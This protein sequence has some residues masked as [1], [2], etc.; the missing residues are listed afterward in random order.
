MLGQTK[1]Q[2]YINTA[3]FT[4]LKHTNLVIGSSGCG[5]HTFITELASKLGL[6]VQDITTKL[7]FEYLNQI[8][9]CP[10]TTLY[11]IDLTLITEKA[12]N[13]IL[14]FIEE[15]ASNNIIF[16]IS[17]SKNLVLPTI[18]N[19]CNIFEF[20]PYTKNTLTKFLEDKQNTLAL[21]YCLTPGQVIGFSK[22]VASMV[23]LSQKIIKNMSRATLAS[24]LTIVDKIIKEEFELNSF[25]QILIEELY[26]NYLTTHS[27]LIYNVYIM[28]CD[29]AK[30]L[31]DARLN[32][33]MFLSSFVISLW[34]MF[35]SNSLE[36]Q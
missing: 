5:K 9:V 32:K 6:E 25:F 29:Y 36:Q 27:K 14:K 22:T 20:E 26:K 13:I 3:D 24:A 7:T 1:L 31:K 28:T 15:P 18:L 34:S 11:L 19:R 17:N 16:L 21:D 12:Q 10:I 8:Y 33:E 30:K 23:I 35:T 4:T 2:Q